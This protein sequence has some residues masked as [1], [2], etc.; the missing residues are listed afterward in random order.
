V[1]SCEENDVMA[2]FTMHAHTVVTYSKVV[3]I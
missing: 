1:Y 3:E 2:Q